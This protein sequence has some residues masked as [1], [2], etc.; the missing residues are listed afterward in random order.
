MGAGG[1][2]PGLSGGVM[3]LAF[4]F[5]EAFLETLAHPK[6]GLKKHWRILLPLG[7]GSVAGFWLTS[8][9][10]AKIFSL[11]E[12]EATCL[13]AGLVAGMF[14]AMFR[15]ANEK[16]NDRSPGPWAAL[17]HNPADSRAACTLQVGRRGNTHPQF[18]VVCLHGYPVGHVY[19]HSG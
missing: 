17:H 9:F 7:L 12:K 5:Y 8:V 18:R 1:I 15:A 6:D 10:L 13:F 3:I 19:G 14:P 11:Y 16:G 4:G 2:L